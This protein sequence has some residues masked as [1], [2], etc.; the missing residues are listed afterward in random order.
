MKVAVCD[1]PGKPLVFKERG[2]PELKEDEVLIKVE[3][4]GV[5]HSDIHIVDGHWKV[6]RYT[7]P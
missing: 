2:I 5:C 6:S 3:H 7:R 4:C 1:E